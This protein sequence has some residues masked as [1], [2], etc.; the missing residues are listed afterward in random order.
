MNG[1]LS[2]LG[3]SSKDLFEEIPYSNLE[4]LEHRHL[5]RGGHQSDKYTNELIS[6]QRVSVGVFRKLTHSYCRSNKSRSE[7][8]TLAL[9]LTVL[10]VLDGKYILQEKTHVFVEAT[11]DQLN[12]RDPIHGKTPLHLAVGEP[13][14]NRDRIERVREI[15]R[16][17]ISLGCD[18]NTVDALGRYPLHTACGRGDIALTWILL[19]AGADFYSVTSEQQTVVHIAA[20]YDQDELLGGLLHYARNVN[21]EWNGEGIEEDNPLLEERPVVCTSSVIAL[22]DGRDENH[23]TPLHVAAFYGMPHTAKFLLD[24]GANPGMRD[25][26]NR[27]ALDLMLQE[28]P[29]V[30]YNA[31]DS[32]LLIDKYSRRNLYNLAA[33]ER[34]FKSRDCTDKTDELSANDVPS[35]IV[36]GNDDKKDEISHEAGSTN[37][38]EIESENEH[39]L[40]I[41]SS[42]VPRAFEL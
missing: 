24:I 39:Y 32:L 33:L 42:A 29:F 8:Q 2:E 17:L 13:I 31:L 37:G 41:R 21:E 14:D 12:E 11:K 7:Y 30:A 25:G 18:V 22:R 5:V 35:N 15:T 23:M 9:H 34:T 4:S 1:R 16:L 28:M 19:D 6:K 27:T 20:R 10:D 3:L 40:H 38:S 36:V 26:K